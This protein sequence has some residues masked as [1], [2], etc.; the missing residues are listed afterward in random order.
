MKIKRFLTCLTL[1]TS[2]LIPNT[3]AYFDMDKFMSEENCYETYS[4]IEAVKDYVNYSLNNMNWTEYDAINGNVNYDNIRE[5]NREI[6]IKAVLNWINYNIDYDFAFDFNTTSYEGIYEGK[7][8]CTGYAMLFYRYMEE[9]NIPCEIYVCWSIDEYGKRQAHAINTVQ[10]EDGLW[11]FVEPQT[12]P[13]PTVRM[14]YTYGI[15]GIFKRENMIDSVIMGWNSFY[16]KYNEMTTNRYYKYAN[17]SEMNIS[18]YDYGKSGEPINNSEIKTVICK[19]HETPQMLRCGYLIVYDATYGGKISG[20]TEQILKYGQNTTPVKAI[21]SE[22]YKFIG[23][24]DG[25]KEQTR[26]DVGVNDDFDII[27]I[28]EKV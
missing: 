23:W 26:M 4:E 19:Q 16:E 18:Y 11:Y 12:I 25:V 7:T 5:Q 17:Y 6:Q 9:L 15:D 22:G 24:S 1:I 8:V 27:A 28:F 21:P 2:M 20:N 14:K 3:Y 13:Y 10:M